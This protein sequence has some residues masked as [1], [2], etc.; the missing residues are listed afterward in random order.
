MYTVASFQGF[1]SPDEILA[2]GAEMNALQDG[3]FTGPLRRG[4]GF[5]CEVC[6]DA[7]WTAHARAIGEFVSRFHDP[8]AQMVARGVSS[9]ID[10]AV[11]PTDLRAANALVGDA[12]RDDDASA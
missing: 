11:E 1:A 10:V 4:R 3:V 6:R 9:A 8:I 12:G 5:S 7:G 2:I